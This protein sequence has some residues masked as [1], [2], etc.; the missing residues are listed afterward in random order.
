MARRKKKKIEQAKPKG[1]QELGSFKMGDYIWCKYFTG[2]LLEGTIVEFSHTEKHGG[3][4]TF[5]TTTQGFRSAH[6]EMC[7]HTKEEAKKLSVRGFL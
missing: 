2:K 5:V 7:A 1:L 4:I 3:V 6:I